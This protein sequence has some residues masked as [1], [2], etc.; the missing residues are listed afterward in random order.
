M[1]IL[2][3]EI[4][5]YESPILVAIVNSEYSVAGP[6]DQLLKRIQPHFPTHP[7]MLVSVEPNGFRAYALFQTHLLLALIQLEIL[8]TRVLDL[9]TPPLEIECA[10]PF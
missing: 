10:L 2:V 6:G 1:E 4:T 9:S 7:I 5:P 8:Q 3:A